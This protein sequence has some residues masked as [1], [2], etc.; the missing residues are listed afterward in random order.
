IVLDGFE[1]A[2]PPQ[3]AEPAALVGTDLDDVFD[4]LRGEADRKAALDAAE[5]DYRRALELYAAGDVD[6]C[7]EALE[8]ASKA[9]KLRFATASRLGRLHRDRGQTAQAIEWLE[10]AAQAPA[11]SPSEYHALLLDLATAL[12]TVGED[13]RALAI[14]LE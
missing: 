2:A 7:I 4:Q 11:P 12:E 13:A 9:P 6:G 3:P 14:C 1:T 10:R 8:A 5:Q